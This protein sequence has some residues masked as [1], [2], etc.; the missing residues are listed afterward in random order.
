MSIYKNPAVDNAALPNATSVA[1]L[2]FNRF[3]YDLA[4]SYAPA[5][6]SEKFKKDDRILLGIIPAGHTLVPVL[7][8]LSI[9]ALESGTPASDY[10]IGTEDDPDALKGTAASETPVVLFGEDWNDPAT[11]IGSPDEDVPIYLTFVTADHDA[12]PNTGKIVF[13][14]VYRA[15]REDIGG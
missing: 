12:T 14:P 6:D 10:Q 3:V 15:Y 2:A 1:D 7:T 5:A 8:R 4:G 13:E 9:P 11:P